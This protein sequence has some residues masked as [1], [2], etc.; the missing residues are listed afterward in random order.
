MRSRHYR[1]TLDKLTQSKATFHTS[2]PSLI[3]ELGDLIDAPDSRDA[4]IRD[5]LRV[6][7]ALSVLSNQ[8]HYV[9]GNHCLQALSKAEFLGT[10][11][12]SRSYYSFDH[13]SFHFVVLD[14]CFRHDGEPYEHG[15]FHWE[16]A[17]ISA[18]QIEWLRGDL[19]AANRHVVVFVHQRLDVNNK[20]G[21]INAAEVREV[22]GKSS[23]VLAVVQ[24][25]NHKN[26]YNEISGIHYVTLMAMVEGSGA[27]NNSYCMM[28]IWPNGSIHIT[29]FGKQASY[30]WGKTN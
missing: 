11:E 23:K 2:A 4:A 12:R 20:F 16:E 6:N 30:Q 10:V 13:G 28:R 5:L 29:G 25:H 9:L 15:N 17:T 21:I 27:E 24:G 7:R 1:E 14:A 22:L 8:R 26:D 18:P 19:Q 3:V